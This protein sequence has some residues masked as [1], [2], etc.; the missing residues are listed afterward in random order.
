MAT[1]YLIRHGQASFGAENYD[2]LSDLGRR[3]AHV[4]GEYLRD[5]GIHL[6]AAYSGDLSR[7]RE[8]CEL[9]LASQ[10]NPVP[11]HIDA[12]FNEIQNDEQ[13]EHLLPEVVKTN[14]AIEALVEKGL[15]DSKDY[16]KVI[17]A[18]FNYWVSD[19]CNEPAIQSW[20]DYAGGAR[21]ALKDVMAAQ[22]SGKT[23][24]IFTSG[25][26]LATLTAHVL[27]LPGE[28]TY[29]L[30]EPVV[31]CSITQLFYNS[32]KVSLSYYND[33]SFLRVL[34]QQRGESLVTYR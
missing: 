18:V 31:N 22:G 8:T 11:H 28:G 23:I 24:G 6:D 17:D 34:G 2:E 25:G 32:S 30:Y 14:P 20:A 5:C 27:G 13:I 26:T 1:I 9:A 4:T 21:Q 3:Q 16:Q 19:A 15:T 7:Q 29:Q 10:P 12:R 33:S